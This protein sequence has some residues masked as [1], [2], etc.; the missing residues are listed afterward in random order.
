MEN[1]NVDDGIIGFEFYVKKDIEMAKRADVGFMIWNGK[2]RGTFNNIINLLNF[3]K[4]VVLYYVPSHQFY[5]LKSM[6]E[7]NNFIERNVKL[8]NKL[9]KLLPKK[10]VTQFA[11]ACLF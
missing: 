4:E 3:E 2:S 11:Q 10:S 9:K 1:V 6:I 5:Y 7:L 8:D